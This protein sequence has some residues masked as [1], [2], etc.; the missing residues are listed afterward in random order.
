MWHFAHIWLVRF[1]F[2]I[3]NPEHN[4]HRSR[5]A[6]QC[7]LLW[8]WTQLKAK[9]LS[10]YLNPGLVQTKLKLTWLAAKPAS[11][12]PQVLVCFLLYLLCSLAWFVGCVLHSVALVNFSLC[13]FLA[14]SCWSLALCFFHSV[15]VQD[16]FFSLF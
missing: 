2:E 10:W 6:V 15:I 14:F 8:R 3:S 4:L 16:F 12:R 13:S 11:Y 5:L 1:Q 9:P 7:K